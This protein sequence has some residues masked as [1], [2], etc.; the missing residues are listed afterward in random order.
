MDLSIS[1]GIIFEDLQ[2]GKSMGHSLLA[3]QKYSALSK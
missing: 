2:K 1:V 3:M